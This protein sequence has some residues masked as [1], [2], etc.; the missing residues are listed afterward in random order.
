MSLTEIFNICIVNGYFPPAW[1]TATIL[2]IPKEKNI[3]TFDQLRP[4]S[5]TPIFARILESFIAKWILE[6]I[7]AK[8]DPK[9]YGNIKSSSTVHY[10]V[11]M[12]H[13]GF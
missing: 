12:L 10:L 5:L 1:K 13:S 9:Q 7:S 8:L 3:T 2:P 4:I 6:D 11:D